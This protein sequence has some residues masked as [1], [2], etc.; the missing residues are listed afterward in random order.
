MEL[1]D[2]KG[3]NDYVQG[4]SDEELQS[5]SKVLDT[6]SETQL[7]LVI[8]ALSYSSRDLINNIQGEINA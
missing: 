3:I 8:E 4:C 5:F 6:V 1:D 7:K 2:Y